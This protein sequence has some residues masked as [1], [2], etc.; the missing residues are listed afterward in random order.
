MSALKKF[1][2]KIDPEKSKPKH[3]IVKYNFVSPHVSSKTVWV[4]LEVACQLSQHLSI[5]SG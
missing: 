3:E 4:P 2:F 1:S 5:K